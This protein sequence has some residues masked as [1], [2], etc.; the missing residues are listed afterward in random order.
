MK[1]RVIFKIA[2]EGDVVALFPATAGSENWHTECACY[3]SSVGHGVA[4][5]DALKFPAAKPEQFHKIFKELTGM[6]YDLEIAKQATFADKEE[7][8]KDVHGTMGFG[9]TN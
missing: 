6:G 1:T 5:L 2:P 3:M 7:R 4:S 9:L 8:R